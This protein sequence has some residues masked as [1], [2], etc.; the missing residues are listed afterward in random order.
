MYIF[1]I[2]DAVP[3]LRTLHAATVITNSGAHV[4]AFMY[5]GIQ[6]AAAQLYLQIRHVFERLFNVFRFNLI[7][8]QINGIKM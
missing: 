7:K 1:I 2:M 6:K 5:V 3:V 4:R 8:C